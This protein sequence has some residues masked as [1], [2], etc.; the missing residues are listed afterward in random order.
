MAPPGGEDHRLRRDLDE[1]ASKVEALA[2]ATDE[3]EKLSRELASV[4]ARIE[5]AEHSRRLRCSTT[6]ASPAPAT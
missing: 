2:A 1:A 6:S 3:K 5:R 4:E